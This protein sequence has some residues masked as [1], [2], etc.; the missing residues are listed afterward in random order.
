MLKALKAPPLNFTDLIISGLQDRPETGRY[1]YSKICSTKLFPT[2]I[3]IIG[4]PMTLY[5]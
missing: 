4:Q 1:I 3:V 5:M 2:D